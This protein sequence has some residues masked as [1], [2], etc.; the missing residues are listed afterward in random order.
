MK[1]KITLFFLVFYFLCFNFVV[2]QDLKIT[3]KVTDES[4]ASLP[5]VSIKV[6][7]TTNGTQ[8][9]LNGD[10]VLNAPSNQSILV[11][12]YLGYTIEEIAIAGRTNL[13]VSLKPDQKSL[14]EV[15]VIG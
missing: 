11:F 13:N 2:A 7:G 10:Y 15:V 3:G 14:Q 1:R 12:S 8:T 4:G 9:N 5:G 6:K